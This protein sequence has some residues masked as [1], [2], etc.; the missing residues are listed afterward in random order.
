MS[1]QNNRAMQCGFCGR[2]MCRN[3]HPDAGKPSALLDVGAM[4]VC[5]PCIV[6][7][8]HMATEREVAARH[9]LEEAVEACAALKEASIDDGKAFD[10]AKVHVALQLANKVLSK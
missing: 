5:V 7:S 1:E 3:P 6:K 2:T 9:A 4:W 8:R 10:E